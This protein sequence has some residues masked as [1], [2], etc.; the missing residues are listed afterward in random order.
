MKATFVLFDVLNQ[1]DIG[2]YHSKIAIPSFDRFAK[3]DAKVGVF[4]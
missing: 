4:Q 2:P 3:G 1:K